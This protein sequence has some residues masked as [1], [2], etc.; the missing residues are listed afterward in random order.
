MTKATQN[1]FFSEYDTPFQI[2]PFEKIYPQHYLPAFEQG[3]EELDAEID[4][5]VDN[6]QPPT[7]ENTIVA[8]EQSGKRRDRVTRVFFNLLSADTNDELNDLAPIISSKLTE[9]RDRIFL[10]RKL[11]N[12]VEELVQK[13]DSLSLNTEQARLLNEI[14]KWFI[15]AGVRLGTEQSAR[16]QEVNKKLATLSIT[17][18]QNLL[19]ESN[20]NFIVVEDAAQLQGLPS[21]LLSQAAKLAG[22]EGHPGKWLFKPN[23]ATL[24]PFL[25]N[26]T[27]R[28]LREAL[29][30]AYIQRGNNNNEFDNKATIKEIV[31][32]RIEKANILGYATHADYVLENKMAKS[33]DRVK[34]LLDR[35]W[36]AALVNA[37]KELRDMQDLVDAQQGGF[38]LAAHDWW[39]YAEKIR[40]QKY[41]FS[42]A[43]VRPYLDA[44]NVLNGA[45]DVANK[46]FGIRFIE[47]FD[48]PK[49]RQEVRSFELQNQAGKTIG[50][51]YIDYYTRPSKRGGAWMSSFRIQNN[52]DG[53]E[54]PIV[55]N[56]CNFPPPV[57]GEPSLL[58]FGQV[59]TLFHEF[60]HGLHGLLS[61]VTYPSL[62][63]TS[64]PSDYV[65]FP[66]QIME[67]WGA[68]PAVIKSYAHHYQ[69][70]EAIPDALL[71][72][73]A[74]ASKFN[75]GFKTTEY[76]A[77]SYLDLAWHS[78][79]EPVDDVLEFEKATLTD[80][81]LLPEIAS[82][83]RSTYFAHIFAGG[84]S[85]GYYSYMWT[86]VLEADGFQLF[87]DK[88]IFD[89]DSADKLYRYVYAA[90]N[91]D[92][93]MTQYVR[94][95]G[96]EPNITSL[97][98]K[99]GL[100]ALG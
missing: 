93:L 15:R 55:L 89:A 23:Q 29:Y 70:G 74:K 75:Q 43:D 94:Y 38:Q 18:R 72:Q 87:K 52:L 79:S 57:D 92:D 76:V 14:Y 68:E 7:F 41:A 9:Q 28:D 47:R 13:A 16:L 69:T 51:F 54:I 20:N 66:S 83:Y 63:G 19:Q 8:F 24:Y 77:A 45:F 5:I 99:R 62:A 42:E 46:L 11:F 95:R 12:R 59:K 25:Q 32:L 84:Y 49:Y 48:L 60:G 26:A 100:V 65:E 90:G 33:A 88:G 35:V 50:I 44:S 96:A 4:K 58:S 82:R 36:Q 97:L 2:P 61:N 34:Q 31:A 86:E 30:S 98:Q 64:V 78:L 67:N 1:P 53:G 3:V 56:V 73:V 22:E 21:G 40:Q 39:F 81:G 80:A 27:Q 37:K 85:A 91:S 71:G 10:N 17:F 6:P